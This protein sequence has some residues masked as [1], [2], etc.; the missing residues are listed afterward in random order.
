[1]YM[2]MMLTYECTNRPGAVPIA[3]YIARCLLD[4]F[5]TLWLLLV[6]VPTLNSSL[7]FFEPPPSALLRLLLVMLA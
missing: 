5:S 1:M 4:R 3:I 2:R 7:Q 6:A